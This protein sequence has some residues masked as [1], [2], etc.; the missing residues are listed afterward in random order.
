MCTPG[1]WDG[2]VT[3]LIELAQDAEAGRAD[4]VNGPNWDVFN[5]LSANWNHKCRYFGKN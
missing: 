4:N 1:N 3:R 2:F 5:C